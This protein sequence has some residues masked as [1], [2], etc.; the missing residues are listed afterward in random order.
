VTKTLTFFK[1][2]I[3]HLSFNIYEG[4]NTFTKDC[5]LSQFELSGILPAESFTC[6]VEVTLILDTSFILSVETV[7]FS[8]I[9]I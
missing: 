4:E 6:S 1:S 8:D 2:N 3:S 5:F 7:L 9:I